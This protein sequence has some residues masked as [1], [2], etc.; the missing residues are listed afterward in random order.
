MRILFANFKIIYCYDEYEYCFICFSWLHISLP[1]NELEEE[2]PF[3]GVQYFSINLAKIRTLFLISKFF[4]VFLKYFLAGPI[5]SPNQSLY[6]STD[7]KFRG[8]G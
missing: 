8:W 3:G 2:H 4:L 7:C 5:F 6:P 1:L